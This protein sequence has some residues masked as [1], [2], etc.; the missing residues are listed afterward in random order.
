M[1]FV[2]HFIRFTF[3]FGDDKRIV[4]FLKNF[5]KSIKVKF[6]EESMIT[7]DETIICIMPSYIT[8]D[9]IRALV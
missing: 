3:S 2:T 1:S 8:L 7:C 4:T 5:E 6:L 9:A